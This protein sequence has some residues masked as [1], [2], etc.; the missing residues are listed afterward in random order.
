MLYAVRCQS[1]AFQHA[2]R[3]IPEGALFMAGE[4]SDSPIILVGAPSAAGKSYFGRALI[5]RQLTSVLDLIEQPDVLKQSVEFRQYDLKSL[6]KQFSD[7]K[8]PIVEIAT[9]RMDRYPSQRFWHNL[10]ATIEARQTIIYV[11]LDVKKSVVCKN[12]FFRI[13]REKKKRNAFFKYLDISSYVRQNWRLLRYLVTNEIGD[14]QRNWDNFG[15]SLLVNR[16]ARRIVFVRAVP[17]GSGYE[18]VIQGEHQADVAPDHS[19][20]GRAYAA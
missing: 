10:L 1:L 7:N 19:L 17:V 5:A 6:P 14:A 11:T 3:R 16:D 9:Q 12:Y 20:A 2:A 13:F 18:I 15:R 8:I 4:C